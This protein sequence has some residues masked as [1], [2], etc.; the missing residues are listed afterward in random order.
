MVSIPEEKR[1]FKGEAHAK[2]ATS[3]WRLQSTPPTGKVDETEDPLKGSFQGTGKANERIAPSLGMNRRQKTR[4]EA[5]TTEGKSGS[6]H[7]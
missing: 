1:K 5:L 6:S 3:Q 7:N 2:E 4:L